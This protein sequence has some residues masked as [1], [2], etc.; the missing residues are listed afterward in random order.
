[1]IAYEVRLK[2]NSGDGVPRETEP[3]D[4]GK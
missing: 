3:L 2:L 4:R 1:V